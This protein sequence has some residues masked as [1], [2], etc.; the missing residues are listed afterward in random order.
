MNAGA[1]FSQR[2]HTVIQLDE[3]LEAQ[4]LLSEILQSSSIEFLELNK[5]QA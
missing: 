3:S 4:Q 1:T 2:A 5:V